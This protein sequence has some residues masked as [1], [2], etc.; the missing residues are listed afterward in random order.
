MFQVL[1]NCQK[2]TLRAF[3]GTRKRVGTTYQLGY[4]L[5]ILPLSV[6]M[7]E[8][9]IHPIKDLIMGAI[10]SLVSSYQAGE[11]IEWTLEGVRKSLKGFLSLG[12]LLR[13]IVSR[14]LIIQL[15][16]HGNV[17]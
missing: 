4:L 3:P 13:T 10:S 17:T 5:G 11:D 6:R 9:F 1:S 14:W 12:G 8:G 16:I 7:L 15:E 2:L